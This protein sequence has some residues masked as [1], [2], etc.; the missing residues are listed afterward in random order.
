MNRGQP[1]SLVEVQNTGIKNVTVLG[2]VLFQI[3]T[4]VNSQPDV[5]N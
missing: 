1:H 2:I 4:N 5:S 3:M